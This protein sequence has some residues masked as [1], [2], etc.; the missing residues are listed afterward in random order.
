M[1]S[2]QPPFPPSDPPPLP[3]APPAEPPPYRRA[4]DR[5]APPADPSKA[6]LAVPVL[7]IA[8]ILVAALTLCAGGLRLVRPEGALGVDALGP[9]FEVALARRAILVSMVLWVVMSVLLA[10]SGAGLLLTKRWGRTL[11]LIYGW[12]T[13]ASM[14]L[15]I[16]GSAVFVAPSL[17]DTDLSPIEVIR[18]VIAGPSLGCCPLVFALAMLFILH[19]DR[20]T[21]WSTH[22][23]NA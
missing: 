14:S 11:G 1:S 3:A 10:V 9:V 8:A 7:G 5:P 22:R 15:M 23:S 12:A 13:V 2:E 21:A 19:L 16:A 17:D 18:A 6:P 20:V 4:A